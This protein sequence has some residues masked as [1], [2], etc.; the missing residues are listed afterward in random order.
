MHT[1]GTGSPLE[2]HRRLDF[3]KVL[4]LLNLKFLYSCGS[5]EL[6]NMKS[7][8]TNGESSEQIAKYVFPGNIKTLN[9]HVESNFIDCQFHHRKQL[10][11]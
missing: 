4:V 10:T 1:V 9:L 11:P 8:D 2:I 5:A 3:D 7:L 6:L